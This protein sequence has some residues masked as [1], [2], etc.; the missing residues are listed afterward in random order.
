MMGVIHQDLEYFDVAGRADELLNYVGYL[1]R[2]YFQ[3]EMLVV[4]VVATTSGASVD[5]F[6]AALYPLKRFR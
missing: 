2:V 5:E 6:R 1:A 3:A 4:R